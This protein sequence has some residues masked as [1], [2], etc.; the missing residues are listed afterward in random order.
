[1]KRNRKE[2]PRQESVNI[3]TKAED[4]AAVLAGKRRCPY[5]KG[6]GKIYFKCIPPKRNYEGDC[7]VCCGERWLKKDEAFR[8]AYGGAV[9]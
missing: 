1:M 7:V 4:V 2:Q 9:R 3:D 5:C 6:T 8:R